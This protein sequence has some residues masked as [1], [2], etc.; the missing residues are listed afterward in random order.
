MD[1][2]DI[3]EPFLIFLSHIDVF[4]EPL[5]SS[6]IALSMTKVMGLVLSDLEVG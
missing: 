4:L 3:L 5:G 6:K 1:L 2:F